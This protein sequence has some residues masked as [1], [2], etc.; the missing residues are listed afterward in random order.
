MAGRAKITVGDLFAG[1]GLFSQAFVDEGA[2]VR[3]AV[4]LDSNA[5]ASYARNIGPHVRVAD[6]TR[7]STAPSVNVIVA[8][9]PCQ[10]FSTLGRRDP[11]DVR[12]R[13][14]FVVPQWA[15][16]CRAQVVVVE[17]VPPFLESGA[18]RAMRR[19]LLAQHFDVTTWTLDACDFGVPQRRRRSFTI[20]SRIGLP[21]PPTPSG[22]DAAKVAFRRI[23]RHDPMHIWPEASPL[24]AARL[25]CLPVSGDRRDL[26][27]RAP[28][29]CP[30]S[31]GKIGCQATDVWGRIDPDV[32]ANTIRCDFQNPSKGRYIH[33]SEN[34]MISLREGARLQQIPEEW[35]MFGHRTAITR[36]IGDGVPLGLGR[37]VAEQV[38]SLF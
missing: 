5:A 26:L 31:W 21:A 12:N 27:K 37:A 14:C 35:L 19:A 18:W 29:L 16:K 24:M 36:Q 8:G 3:F 17:N 23:S 4:E 38:L 6:A 11:K 15:Q 1:A 13:L 10:G 7:V 22:A 34:R 9:P 2:R 25:R 28:G 33:P 20:A 30:P 32:P